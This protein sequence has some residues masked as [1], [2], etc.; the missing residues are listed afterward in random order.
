MIPNM[1]FES[2]PFQKREDHQHS[3][4]RF[5]DRHRGTLLMLS[6]AYFILR[7]KKHG[8]VYNNLFFRDRCKMFWFRDAKFQEVAFSVWFN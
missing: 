5:I 7:K 6:L 1:R 8:A 3:F 4:R 2:S